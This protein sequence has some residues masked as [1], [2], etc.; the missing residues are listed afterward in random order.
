MSLLRT[1]AIA[2][3]TTALVI[4]TAAPAHA[5]TVDWDG[6]TGS[7]DRETSTAANW[8]GD[9]LP[10]A[11]DDWRFTTGDYAHNSLPVDTQ[12]GG[13]TFDS[14]GFLLAGTRFELGALGLDAAQSAETNADVRLTASQTWTVADGATLVNRGE[15]LVLTGELELAPLGVIEFRGRLDGFGGAGAVTQ[16]SGTVLLSGSGGT[17]GAGGYRIDGGETRVT[18]ELGGTD[19]QLTGGGAVLSGTGIVRTIT[20][21]AGVLS[22]GPDAAGAGIGELESWNT[23]TLSPDSTLRLDVDAA[24][25]DSLQVYLGADLAGA[26]LDLRVP[27]GVDPIARTTIVRVGDGTVAPALSSADGP[28]ALGE[29]FVSG[30]H[31]WM[32][33]QPD[34]STLDLV[35]IERVVVT[36]PP[37]GEEPG[38]QPTPPRPAPAAPELAATGAEPVGALTAIALLLLAAGATATAQGARRARRSA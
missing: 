23:V 4:G 18:A 34:A 7:G 33:E 2:A 13:L 12:V 1:S 6:P 36:P 22:P 35:W 30:G 20:S 27:E 3:T 9:A 17:I 14:P 32:L 10:L 38:E 31:R 8:A 25:S 11:G 29:P 15:I 16:S 26:L 37:G 21:T 19:V 5:A 24:G 28:I